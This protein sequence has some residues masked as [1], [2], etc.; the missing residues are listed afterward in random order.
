M[1]ASWVVC[2]GGL[3]LLP[4]VAA[5]RRTPPDLLIPV[6]A[7]SSLRDVAA[8]ELTP[9]GTRIR[10]NPETLATFGP[11]MQRF[12]LAH[13]RAHV[14]LHHRREPHLAPSRIARMELDADCAATRAL[15][16][17]GDDRAIDAAVRFFSTEGL[18][19]RDPEHQ[20]GRAHV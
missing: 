7:D 6:V 3:G 16:R 8:A 18:L 15:V 20:I 11:E 17:K 2:I 1:R 13:E 5:A 12:I 19:A 10:V 9:G 14:T 4:L